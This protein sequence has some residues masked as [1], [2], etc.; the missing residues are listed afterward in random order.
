MGGL[1][2]QHQ[3]LV[4]ELG[5]AHE[6]AML[7]HRA[8]I[9]GVIEVLREEIHARRFGPVGI[10]GQARLVD[11]L[12]QAELALHHARHCLGP[13]LPGCARGALWPIGLWDE[14]VQLLQSSLV[15]RDAEE[16]RRQDIAP[17]MVRAGGWPA[18]GSAVLDGCPVR[19]DQQLDGLQ[20]GVKSGSALVGRGLGHDDARCRDFNRTARQ[21]RPW[22]IRGDRH[23]EP[24][25]GQPFGARLSS[26]IDGD[27]GRLQRFRRMAKA[28]QLRRDGE[29][30]ALL[31]MSDVFTFKARL[32]RG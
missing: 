12:R 14:F 21:V 11:L 25:D 6:G 18:L 32:R 9:G 8:T 16:L 31:S 23:H 27:R 4:G 5:F 10:Q 3:H 30:Q 20:A 22:Y 26:Q 2:R 29:P 1:V 24:R 15:Q 17:R 19:V 7:R 28:A 13:D